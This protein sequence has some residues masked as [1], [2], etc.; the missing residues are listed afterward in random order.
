MMTLGPVIYLTENLY[1]KANGIFPYRY[2]GSDQNN[3]PLYYGSSKDL[4]EDIKKLGL[5]NFKKIII[6]E[7]ND[8]PNKDLRK[9][10]AGY[11]KS[12]N[13]KNDPSY[14]NKSDLYAPGGGV[15]GMKHKNPRSE[16]YWKKW[17][18][19]R[20]GHA[21]SEETRALWSAQRKGRK[22]SS[23]TKKKM[24]SARLGEKNS[25]ALEWEIK[26]PTGKKI[27]VK[28]LR[29][30]CRDISLPFYRIYNSSHGWESIKY[31]TGNNA[32]QKRNSTNG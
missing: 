9:L 14:Y 12:Y 17:S 22:A 21:V 29:A 24:S 15:K 28:G 7:F 8:L 6:E 18:E 27:K 10:E 16:E 20:I 11:L 2:I 25:N 13:V 26:F 1:N 30:Y 31:G 19:I 32:K 4:K 5:E 23:E 3:D